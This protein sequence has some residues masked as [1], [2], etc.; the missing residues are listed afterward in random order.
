MK[1]FKKIIG[2]S[3]AATPFILLFVFIT[4]KHNIRMA[5][6][7]YSGCIFVVLFIWIGVTLIFDE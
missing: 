7:L 6:G 1:I 5:L 3:M 2:W 4:L